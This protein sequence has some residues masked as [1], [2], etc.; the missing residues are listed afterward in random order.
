MNYG[1]CVW[2]RGVLQIPKLEKE[3]EAGF[4]RA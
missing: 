3:I 1:V 4:G 2:A